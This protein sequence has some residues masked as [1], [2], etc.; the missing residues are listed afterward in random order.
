M[1]NFLELPLQLQD[2]ITLFMGLIVEAF[3]F[4]VLGG[5]VSALVAIFISPDLVARV[6]PKNKIVSHG[7]I[8]VTGIFMPV[9]ECGNIPVARRMV[10]NGFNAS[11]AITFLLAAP[12]INPITLWSTVE[13]FGWESGIPQIRVVSAYL[14]AVG[15]GLAFSFVKD[16]T[17]LL[18]EHFY[19]VHCEHNHDDDDHLHLPKELKNKNL[20]LEVIKLNPKALNYF[21]NRLASIFQQEFLAVMPALIIGAMVAAATQTFI[22]REFLVGLATNPIASVVVMMVLAFV[23]SICANVDAFFALSYA[24]T[25]TTGSIL[26]FLTFGPMIDI[27]ILSMLSNTFKVKTIVGIAVLVGLATAVLGLA[28]NLFY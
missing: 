12:I 19:H 9:C 20:A 6:L 1:L 8:A 16:Q 23:I 27:K 11:Q 2:F 21:F 22:P 3:P 5:L 26:T 7:L 17:S 25:F 14:I 24:T 10:A 13:A 4:V 28:V 15:I 18:T